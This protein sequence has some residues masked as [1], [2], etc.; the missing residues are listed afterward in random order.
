MEDFA[1][2]PPADTDA[3]ILLGEAPPPAMD[4]AAVPAAEDAFVGTVDETPPDAA[5][6]LLGAP[7]PAED[8][9]VPP[10]GE[11]GAVAEESDPADDPANAL[12]PLEPSPMQKWN[13]SWQQTLLER[14]DEENAK[15]AEYLA[16]AEEAMKTFHEQRES[17]RDARM[18]KNRQDEQEK[19][20][21]I[22]ADLENDN[23]WQRVCKMVE[24]SHDSTEKAADVKRMRDVMIV[25]K[26][27]A[28]RATVLA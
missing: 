27:D 22:E 9:P 3:P 8:P 23:S 10:S 1:T 5:P 4:F 20:E 21:A 25:L 7:P 11:E 19:L 17:K 16:A 24:L 14:K 28:T 26:N 15:K 13:E 18:S 12:T 2:P 6:I